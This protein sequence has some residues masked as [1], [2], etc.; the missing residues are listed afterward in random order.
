MLIL[1]VLIVTSPL[2]EYNYS[3]ENSFPIALG[4]EKYQAKYTTYTLTAEQGVIF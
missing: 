1:Y 3:L 2:S 4:V